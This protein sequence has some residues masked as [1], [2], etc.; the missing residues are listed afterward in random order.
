MSKTFCS[1]V[2]F[3]VS[4][5]F[6]V[7]AA[8]GPSNDVEQ[9]R[10]YLSNSVSPAD[11]QWLRD[12][13]LAHL[14]GC[15]FEADD[16]TRLFTPDGVAHY[17]ALWTRDF[18]YT[19]HNA[20]ALL[21]PDEI[22]A[23]IEYLLRGQRADGCMPDRVT[24]AGKPIYAP[25]AESNP[26]ADHALDNGPF[27][28][29]LVADYYRLSR[30]DT[31][32]RR[33]E[34]AL[35][36]GLDFVRRAD[37]G[38]VYNDPKEP[39]CPYGFT[40]C[41]AK[42]G[43]LL[44]VSLLYYDACLQTATACR[45]AHCGEPAVYERRAALIRDNLRLLWDEPSGMFLAADRDCRQIDIWGSALALYLGIASSEQADRICNY[46]DRHAD[47][48]FQRGQV[49]HLPGRETWSR[50]L[51]P[52]PAQRYQNGA[53]WATPH[54]WLLPALA[55]RKPTLAAR[56]LNETI[57]DFRE[58][59]VNECVNGDYK[60]VPKYVVSATNVCGAIKP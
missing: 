12:A 48:V 44:F 47:E 20:G 1:I 54:A 51:T 50:L 23:G 46:L 42:T 53:F 45:E 25:G 29:S 10:A 14:D 21:D 49:R 32:F 33:H 15:V 18:A 58:N 52:I 24:A 37:N 55:T 36:R 60:G 31:F 2:L 13:T 40:D 30:D 17:H 39:Q 28:A 27:M 4:C 41:V 59:G 22:R 11:K 56:L 9:A 16:G 43:H 6:G 5:V 8:D 26:L 34:P 3:V 38:L 7:V 35:R 57:R 19:V